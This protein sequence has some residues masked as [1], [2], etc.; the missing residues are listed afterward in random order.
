MRVRIKN[1]FQSFTYINRWTIRA[2]IAGI[3][4]Y[5]FAGLSAEIA[6]NAMLA[7]F[8]ALL[9]LITAISLFEDYFAKLVR[10][11]L[12]RYV[13]MQAL[14]NESVLSTLHDLAFNFRLVAPDLAW[15]LVAN[16]VSELTEI[17]S[18]SLFSVSFIAAIWISSSVVGAAMNA[19]DHIHQIP[20]RKRRPFWKAKLVSIFLTLG[21]IGLLVIA[22]FLV[23][24]GHSLVRFIVRLLGNIPL[25]E[26]ERGAVLLLELW[27]RLNW[28]FALTIVM[29]AFA[30]LYRFAPSRWREGTPILPG[31]ILAAFSWAGI[32]SIFRLYVE[33]FGTYNKVYGTVGAV[34][35]LML[36]LYLTALVLLIGGL[37]NVTLGNA[38]RHHRRSQLPLAGRLK[39]L[40]KRQEAKDKRQ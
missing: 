17:K 14:E 40:G 16:F 6:Y 12:V 4:R 1:F 21:S 34:I 23:L 20:R 32:S 3:F 19:L 30:L 35:V 18:T 31:A 15:E 25:R 13:G 22:S 39:S 10:N 8:P 27:Q 26:S 5:R 2:T 9:T 7:L 11:L 37:F 33:N 38:K 28:P 24:I 36:W 29:L